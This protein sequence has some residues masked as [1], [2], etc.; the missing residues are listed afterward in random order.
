MNKE[1]FKG[2]ILR[3]GD[4]I[5]DPDEFAEALANEIQKT[6]ESRDSKVTRVIRDIETRGE[7][8]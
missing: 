2:A 7:W 4:K 3:V 5:V 1:E 6:I 8:G